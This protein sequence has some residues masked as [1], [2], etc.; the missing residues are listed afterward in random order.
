MKIWTIFK[1]GGT[2]DIQLCNQ[3]RKREGEER[4]GKERGEKRG[5]KERGGEERGREGEREGEG[6][7]E[8]RGREGERE[9]E[10]E[11]EEIEEGERWTDCFFFVQN[12]FK[13]HCTAER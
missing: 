13:V 9:G 12:L 3:S 5:E 1:T 7:G 2:T 8:E 10:G 6:E 11:G 4:G